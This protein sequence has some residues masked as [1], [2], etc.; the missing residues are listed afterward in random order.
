GAEATVRE[1]RTSAQ[2]SANDV[3]VRSLYGDGVA[4]FPTQVVTFDSWVLA[5]SLERLDLVKVDVE[6]AEYDVLHGM[7]AALA[8]LRP[9]RLVVEVA[10][11]NLANAGRTLEDLVGLISDLGYEPAGPSIAEVAGGKW[12]G[13]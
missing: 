3:G 1:L 7:R 5:P 13:L 11:D 10:P 2:F 8:R 9:R 4:L 6:G 12:R